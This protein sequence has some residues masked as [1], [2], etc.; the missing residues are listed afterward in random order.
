M[1]TVSGKKVSVKKY[2]RKGNLVIYRRK[3]NT[4]KSH[5]RGK[6]KNR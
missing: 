4:V 6:P 5:N 1:T 3:A 2:K